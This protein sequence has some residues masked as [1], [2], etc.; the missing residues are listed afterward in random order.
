[1]AEQRRRESD[2]AHPTWECIIWT[3]DIDALLVNCRKKL[4]QNWIELAFV[5]W[6]FIKFG[7]ISVVDRYFE[8]RQLYEAHYL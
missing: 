7:G 2:S 4:V 5:W 3:Y 6:D 1:M 8:R